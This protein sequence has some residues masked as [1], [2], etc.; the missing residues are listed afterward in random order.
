M[1]KKIRI[2][3]DLDGVI[4]DKPP[5]IPKQFIEWLFK[6]GFCKSKKLY[7][8]F[9]KTSLEQKIRKISHFY[10]FRPLINENYQLIKKLSEN[11]N[12]NLTIISS[13]YSFLFPETKVL[14]RKNKIDKLFDKVYLNLED[15]QPHIFKEEILK[16][17]IPDF[18]ID[19]DQEIIGYLRDRLS[20][21]KLIFFQKDRTGSLEN[22][23]F[24]E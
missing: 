1:E 9:P 2:A 11:K 16:K 8:Y 13:R 17:T 19:D 22:L 20:K 6:G 12:Y 5:L 24:S 15:K 4:V 7:F 18:F 14:L 23:L 10:L 21:T 3:F